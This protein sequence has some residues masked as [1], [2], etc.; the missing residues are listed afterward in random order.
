MYNFFYRCSQTSSDED[1]CVPIDMVC[2]N[3]K[4]CPNG[5]DERTCIGLKSPKGTP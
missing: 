4:D 5:E 2:D 3:V 1:Y